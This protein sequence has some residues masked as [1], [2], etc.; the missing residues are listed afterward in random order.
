[1]NEFIS[2]RSDFPPTESSVSRAAKG[3]TLKGVSGAGTGQKLVGSRGMEYSL[4]SSVP[5]LPSPKGRGI[6]ATKNSGNESI[7]QCNQ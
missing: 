6:S 4:S 2:S 1:M 5:S 3:S 7:Y